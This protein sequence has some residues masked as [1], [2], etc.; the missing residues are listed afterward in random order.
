[1]YEVTQGYPYFIQEFGKQTWDM[2]EEGSGVIRRSDVERSLPLAI[3]ELDSGFFRVRIGKTKDPERAYLRAMA[4]L[5]PGIVKSAD[6]AKILKKRTTQVAPVRDGLLKKALCYSPRF[7]ELAF[8]VPMFDEFMK[9]WIPTFPDFNQCRPAQR[10]RPV[11]SS[12][13]STS[14]NSHSRSLQL[15]SDGMVQPR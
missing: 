3:A 8:T 11:G 2:A 5:G 13:G 7:N 4:E 12:P 14:G 6:V 9:R 10:R 1:M 15:S